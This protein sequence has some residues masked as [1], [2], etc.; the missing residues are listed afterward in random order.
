MSVQTRKRRGTNQTVYLGLAYW[1]G[2]IP[3]KRKAR[4]RKAR[5]RCASSGS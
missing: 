2:I 3:V 1:V 5:K 4:K